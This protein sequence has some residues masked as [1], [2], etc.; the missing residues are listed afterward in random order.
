MKKV[1]RFKMF[2]VKHLLCK[3]RLLVL[4]YVNFDEQNTRKVVLV[5]ITN[6]VNSCMGMKYGATCFYACCSLRQ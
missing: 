5:G 6:R 4:H 1:R 3:F 2:H